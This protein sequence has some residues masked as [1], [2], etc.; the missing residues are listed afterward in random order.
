MQ[1]DIVDRM[2]AVKEELAAT[3]KPRFISKIPGDVS[4]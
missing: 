1:A 4:D 3:K 2:R